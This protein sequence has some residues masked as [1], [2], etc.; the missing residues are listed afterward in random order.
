[1]KV[2]VSKNETP[3][4]EEAITFYFILKCLPFCGG[5]I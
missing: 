3:V 1:M 2:G 5:E 4:E